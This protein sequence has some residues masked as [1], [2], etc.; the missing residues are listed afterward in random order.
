MD[1]FFGVTFNRLAHAFENEADHIKSDRAIKAARFFDPVKPAKKRVNGFASH[2]FAAILQ[3]CFGIAAP[4][5][6]K[7]KPVDR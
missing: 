5:W 6:R 2:L 4:V 1:Q 7:L 3:K